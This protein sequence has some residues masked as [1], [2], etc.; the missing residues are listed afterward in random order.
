MHL[1]FL[2]GAT[3]TRC[4]FDDLVPFFGT[5]FTVHRLNF[6]G[7]GGS[8]ASGPFTIAAFADFVNGYIDEQIIKRSSFPAAV[9][10]F[11][12]S[13]GGN[14]A[15]YIA[16]HFPARVSSVVTLGTKLNWDAEIASRE[17]A[18]LDAEKIGLKVPAF[19]AKLAA[20]H[21]KDHWRGV[22]TSTRD[23]LLD[24][25][26]HNPLQPEDFINI[27]VK[28]LLMVGDRDQMVSIPETEN[29][30]RTI[31][32]AAFCVLPHTP[33]PIDKVKPELI[34]YWIREFLNN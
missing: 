3:G 24:M 5:E 18:M 12:Y 8:P 34:S 11:G 22:L 19:A 28:T 31:P 10:L 30:Y 9:H 32:N 16:R 27:P 2:H 4:Q 15:L 25:G 29:V 20:E 33:H 7:H 23:M 14:V 26:N 1:I 21:G 13:M 6:P 17:A